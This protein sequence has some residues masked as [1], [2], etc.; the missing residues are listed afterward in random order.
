MKPQ[1][2]RSGLLIRELPD[3]VLVYDQVRPFAAPGGGEQEEQGG[4]P[5][6]AHRRSPTS[7]G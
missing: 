7:A 2:R 6:A 3:E 4:N 5:G 1:T